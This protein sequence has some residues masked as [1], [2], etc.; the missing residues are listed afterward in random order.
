MH[1]TCCAVFWRKE[2]LTKLYCHRIAVSYVCLWCDW[3]V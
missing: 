2:E 1:S 3:S